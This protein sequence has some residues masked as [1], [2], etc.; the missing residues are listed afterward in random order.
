LTPKK[1][2]IAAS[3]LCLAL[4]TAAAAA[5]KHIEPGFSDDIRILVACNPQADMGQDIS[6]GIDWAGFQD[7]DL[8]TLKFAENEALITYQNVW[9]IRQFRVPKKYLASRLNYSAT[10]C[11]A[12][13]RYLLIGKDGGV[14]RRW[15]GKLSIDELFQTIDAMPMRQYEMRT[16]GA[17]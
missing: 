16:R 8:A 4:P 10:D 1:L 9:G 2:A 14:K 5:D 3:L 15:T 6:P 13:D 11:K 12:N 7:R 17:N